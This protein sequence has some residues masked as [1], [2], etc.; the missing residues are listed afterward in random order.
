ML[1][2]STGV[3]HGARADRSG[4]LL[5]SGLAALGFT[6]LPP[7]VV[8]DGVGPVAE[9]LRR[10]ADEAQVDVILTSGGTGLTPDDLTP[11][12]TRQVVEREVPG[13]AELL[14]EAGRRKTP[15]AVLSRGIAGVRGRTLIV[16]VAGSVGAARDALEALAP[17]LPHALEL[18]AGQH[19]HPGG[20][21][22]EA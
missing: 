21:A 9:A 13:L 17:L 2:V 19:H 20:E 7:M 10:L 1:T 22:E 18:L 11:E 3:Y 6:V 5:R 12:A 4:E 14:R 16:N 8:P 15:F